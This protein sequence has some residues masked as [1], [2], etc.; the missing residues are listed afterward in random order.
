MN[1][2]TKSPG[3]YQSHLETGRKT[4]GLALLCIFVSVFTYNPVYPLPLF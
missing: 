1:A 4:G 2:G 3:Q